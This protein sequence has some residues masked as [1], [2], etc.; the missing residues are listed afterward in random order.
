MDPQ[1]NQYPID[2]LNQIAP[3][4][5]KQGLSSKL[6]FLLI[7][8]GVLLAI[9][10]GFFLLNSGSGG[11]KEKMQTLAARMITLQQIAS[12]SQRNIKSG[13]LRATNS[14]LT[15]F[16]TNANRDIAEPL[17]NNNIDVKKLDQGIVTKEDG[18]ELKETLN[19][20]RLNAMF[21][22]TYAREMAY[23]LDTIAVLMGDIYERTNSKSLKDF[24]LKT[25]GDLQPIKKT[26]SEFTDNNT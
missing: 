14:S 7:G 26:F 13:S 4:Q 2:Y 16:L 23:Q 5:P 17:L 10:V 20:A 21:D 11:P 19:D 24:L 25:D 9:V 12:D 22:R 18:A 8:G 1:Q 3:Q 6:F 15:I